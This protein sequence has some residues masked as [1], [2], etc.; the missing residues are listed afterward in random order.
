MKILGICASPRK[1]QTTYKALEICMNEVAKAPGAEV[2]LVQL[3]EMK[4]AGCI[5][6]GK[7][8]KELVCSQD[9]GFQQLLPKLCDPQLAGLVLATPVYFGGPTSQAKAFLDRCVCLRRNGFVLADKVAGVL[10]VGGSRNGGQELTIQAIHAAL[11][12]QGMIVVSDAPPTAHF[13][14]MAWSGGEGGLEA[15]QVGLSTVANLGKRVGMVAA[16]LRNM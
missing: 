2:E 3:A 8:A 7:C 13:G 12:I 1:K 10:A 9:D 6:C 14:G 4:V 11:L 5:S 15:D 16:R